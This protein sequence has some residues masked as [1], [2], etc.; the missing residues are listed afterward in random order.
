MIH[1][2]IK[3]VITQKLCSYERSYVSSTLCEATR[4]DQQGINMLNQV[5]FEGFHKRIFEI[6]TRLNRTTLG[7]WESRLLEGTPETPEL[8]EVRAQALGH[9]IASLGVDPAII[10]DGTAP[11]LQ[12]DVEFI[13]SAKEDIEFLLQT[14]RALAELTAFMLS[15]EDLLREKTEEGHRRLLTLL[16]LRRA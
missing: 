3:F 14:T 15:L 13:V 16:P 1:I 6:Q 10:E 7:Q 5:E 2:H 4:N 9:M 11:N 8:Y 12:G